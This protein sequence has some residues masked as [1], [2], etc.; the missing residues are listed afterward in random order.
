MIRTNP[1]TATA[2]LAM[3]DCRRDG[4]YYRRKFRSQI[5]NNMDRWQGRG[6]KSQRRERK[7]K[8][9]QRRERVRRRK[10]LQVR[11]KV[12]SQNTVFLVTPEGRKCRR[13]N[14]AGAEP[15]GEMR[16]KANQ[17]AQNTPGSEHFWQL[18]RSKSTP[19]CGA[20][21][22]SKSKCAKHLSSRTFLEVAMLKNWTTLWREAHLEAKMVKMPHG[23][24]TFGRWA[25]QKVYAATAWNCAKQISKW[26]RW[27]HQTYPNCSDHFWKLR[28]PKSACCCGVKHVSKS[29]CEKHSKFGQLL[30]VQPHHTTR[31][32]QL[33]HQ[34]QQLQLQ[35]RPALVLCPQLFWDDCREPY[36]CWPLQYF[37]AFHYVKML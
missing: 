28:C 13:A 7:N 25:L 8:Q 5:S 19:P 26:K 33:Q 17:N 9:G 21:H 22:I 15:S 11:E 31:Q 20:K 24:S 30:D 1:P 16:A 18:R 10:K 4:T 12:K 32:L 6:G 27:K 14:A 35:L 23:R 36:F 3:S 2:M 37:V 29:K 34:H